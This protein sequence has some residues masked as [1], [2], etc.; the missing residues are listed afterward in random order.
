MGNKINVLNTIFLIWYG[1]SITILM[2][3]EADKEFI[4]I[5]IGAWTIIYLILLFILKITNSFENEKN[6]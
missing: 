4:F 3:C 1:I 2:L 6:T 5:F